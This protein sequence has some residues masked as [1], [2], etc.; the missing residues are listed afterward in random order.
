MQYVVHMYWVL[1]SSLQRWQWAYDW[2]SWCNEVVQGKVLLDLR[3]EAC[4]IGQVLSSKLR[5]GTSCPIYLM[6]MET[7]GR[8]QS[9]RGGGHAGLR[10]R[11]PGVSV[12]PGV[13]LCMDKL[14]PQWRLYREELNQAPLGHESWTC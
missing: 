14:L 12:L 5:P 8:P 7:R 4:D 2:H 3:Y 11:L 6:G 13:Y 10:Q 1:P 9:R